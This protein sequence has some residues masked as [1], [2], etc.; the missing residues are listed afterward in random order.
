MSR[1]AVLFGLFL[2]LFADVARAETCQP[3]CRKGYVCVKGACVSACNPP[4]AAGE[5]CTEK[6][7]CIS[8]PNASAAPPAPP[9][10]VATQPTP[11]A[12]P[13][14]ATAT[15]PAAEPAPAP[16]PPAPPAAVAPPPDAAPPPAASPDLVPPDS[17]GGAPGKRSRYHDGFYFQFALGLGYAT[18][19][20][21]TDTLEIEAEGLAQLGQLAL[22]GTIAPGLVLGGGF[23]GANVFT[24]K[25][26]VGPKNNSTFNKVEADGELSS[27]SVV[28][29]FVSYYPNP[30]S[31]LFVT[32]GPGIAVLSTGKADEIGIKE[33]SGS[34]FGFVA[35]AGY[36]GFV[37]EQW[38]MGVMGRV[39]YLSAELEDDNNVKS[40]FTGWVPGVLAT[41]TLH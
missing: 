17:S 39:L 21:E 1:V 31:G 26:A 14:P 24:T 40:D 33:A 36:E 35:G 12:P 20:A 10:P 7:E 13:P 2:L 34:G 18:G 8:D 5:R 38:S 15:P 41:L 28:A 25:Y 23:F 6:G 32:A 16:P 9:P 4:C 29:A 19:T 30:E 27:G 22:G 11:P 37:G 3:A